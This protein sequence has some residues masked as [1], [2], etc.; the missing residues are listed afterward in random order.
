MQAL[1]VTFNLNGHGDSFTQEVVS[2]AKASAPSTPVSAGYVFVGWYSDQA[3]TT[4]YNFNT[5]IT[6]AK[7]LYAKWEES[8]NCYEFTLA[9]SGTAPSVGDVILGTGVGG[10]MTMIGGTIEYSS[11]GL[12]FKSSGSSKVSV[13]LLT[14]MQVGTVITLNMY[15]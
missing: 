7:T 9:T 8:N 11:N 13:E 6:S 12:A 3:C 5:T 1:T 4:E 10:T 15:K 2:G 14:K